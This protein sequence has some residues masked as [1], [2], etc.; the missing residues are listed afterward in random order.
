MLRAEPL[1]RGRRIRREVWSAILVGWGVVTLL[2]GSQ[3]KKGLARTSRVAKLV[4]DAVECESIRTD[5]S[6]GPGRAVQAP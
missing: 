3:E 1:P 2:I 5:Q 6:A 4:I